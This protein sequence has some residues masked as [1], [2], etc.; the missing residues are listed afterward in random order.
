M[1]RK[2]NTWALLVGMEIEVITM[3][4]NIESP[5]NI[6]IRLSNAAAIPI[7]GRHSKVALLFKRICTPLSLQHFKN[8]QTW[9]QP[10]CLL[11]NERES[12]VW[13]IRTTYYPAIKE[14]KTCHLPQHG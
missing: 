7:L 12:Q 14:K 13:C 9:K 4:N 1:G 6:K 3:Q 8:S 10:K 2:G 5:Q 11:I